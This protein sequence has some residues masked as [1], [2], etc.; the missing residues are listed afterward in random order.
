MAK[1]LVID[2]GSVVE[3]LARFKRDAIA[4][5]TQYPTLQKQ[6]PDQFIAIYEGQVI[7]NNQD[8]ETLT[9]DLQEQGFDPRFVYVNRVYSG[10]NPTLILFDRA[11]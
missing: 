11:A 6:F 4:F 8:P 10:H 3:G 1:G 9:N 5:E 2:I 7:G